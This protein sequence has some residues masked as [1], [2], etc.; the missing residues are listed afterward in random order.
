MPQPQNLQE[1]QGFSF[2]RA[3]A[4]LAAH[5]PLDAREREAS[6]AVAKIVNRAPSGF[7]IP[8]ARRDLNASGTANLGG[9]TVQ[10]D[11]PGSQ[12]IDLLLAESVCAK[13]GAVNLT[14]LVGDV[15]IPSGA[16]GAIAYWVAE[17]EQTTG[18]NPTFG[19]VGLTPHRLSASCI[20]SK[21]LLAQ[22]SIDVE[23]YVRS[24]LARIIAVELDR[25]ALAGT[26]SNGQPTGI[27]STSNVGSVTFGGAATY[28]KLIEFETALAT[29]NALSGSLAY[30]VS[31]A[32]CA[33]W[34]NTP[35]LG[36]VVPEFLWSNRE[37]GKPSG[38]LG[39]V[40][41]YASVSTTHL[42]GS[43]RVVFG[44]FRDLIIASW[45]GLDVI[46]DPY[47]LADTHQIKVT[48]NLLCDIAVRHP[49]SFAISSDSGAQ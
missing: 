43:D 3:I 40:D 31:P 38:Q 16:S 30:V 45:A 1:I 25:V 12:F 18:S 32:T 14:G 26:G 6:N 13:L 35:K 7:Y 15:A 33:K 27:L 29:T 44:N 4:R 2:C 9:N 41:G 49:G 19:Q 42:T 11:V 28:T 34:K 22:S 20:I 8:L 10:T 23:G 24:H 17:N 5:E 48:V 39:A 47:T 46:V 21:R 37:S 36:S